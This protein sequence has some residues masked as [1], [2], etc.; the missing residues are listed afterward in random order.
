MSSTPA[1]RSPRAPAKAPTSCSPASPSALG[2]DVENLTLTGVGNINGTGNTG[3]NT[4]TGNTGNNSL[5]GGGGT[6]TLIGGTGDDTYVVDGSDTVT[7]AAGEGTDLVQ[8]SVTYT[9]GANVENLTLTGTGSINGTGNADANTITGNAGDNTLDG[10]AG[11]DTLIGGDG[12]DTYVVDDIGERSRRAPARAR[13]EV[14][15]TA[16]SFTLGANV[17][18]LTL[19]GTGNIN[20]TGNDRRQHHHRQHRQQHARRRPAG[21]IT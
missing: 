13:D 16:A 20:G 5:D 14:H 12:N 10:G 8:S 11:A 7:E 6:D 21:P 19:T 9:L 3:A 2:A 4:I 15:S 1:T 18:N 17:E